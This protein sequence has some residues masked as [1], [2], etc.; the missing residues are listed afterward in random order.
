MR[1]DEMRCHPSTTF[2]VDDGVARPGEE[3]HP[4]GT[5]Q[6]L[7]HLEK[8]RRRDPPPTKETADR[9]LGQSGPA[10]RPSSLRSAW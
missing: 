3:Q 9:E 5:E 4:S 1:F 10:S 6:P 8:E 7:I 2:K